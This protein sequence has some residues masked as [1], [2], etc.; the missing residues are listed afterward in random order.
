MTI[1]AYGCSLIRMRQKKK[2]WLGLGIRSSFG[3]NTHPLTHQLYRSTNMC[4]FI[5]LFIYFL[6]KPMYPM[7]PGK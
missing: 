1:V 6:G 5:Y 7:M 2:T 4:V 3:Q